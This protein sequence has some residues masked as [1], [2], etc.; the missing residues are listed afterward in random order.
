MSVH[1]KFFY[2]LDTSTGI[3]VFLDVIL[4][5]PWEKSNII[6]IQMIHGK[7]VPK[8]WKVGARVGNIG[9]MVGKI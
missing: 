9:D 5:E 3:T 1:S 8:G 2:E 4:R 7:T 6:K